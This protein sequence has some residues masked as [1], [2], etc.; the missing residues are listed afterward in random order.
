MAGA[1]VNARDNSQRSVLHW[2]A[3]AG[4]ARICRLL[5]DR[6]FDV[7]AKEAN[8]RSPLYV[9]VREGHCEVVRVMLDYID[10]NDIK[11]DDTY[12]KTPLESAVVFDQLAVVKLLGE[13]YGSPLPEGS[14]RLLHH[15][16]ENN[17]KEMLEYLVDNGVNVS[18]K[19]NSDQTA[20]QLAQ[21][22]G[23][24]EMI[25]ILRA[26]MWL[27]CFCCLFR[28]ANCMARDLLLTME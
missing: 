26:G 11:L 10:N 21:S 18:L 25:E 27:V 3:H 23:R 20:L 7:N 6:G 12:S 14:V 15:A 19:D 28:R 13:W 5:L 16:V 9:A 8:M 2:A 4:D 24:K 1:S 17:N 22:L